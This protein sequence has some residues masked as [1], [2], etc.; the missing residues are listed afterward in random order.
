MENTVHIKIANLA[1]N[2]GCHILQDKEGDICLL[3][4]F[5]DDEGKEIV[6]LSPAPGDYHSQVSWLAK[7]ASGECYKFIC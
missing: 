3:Q 7:T 2:L 1:V 5:Y 4:K 6:R